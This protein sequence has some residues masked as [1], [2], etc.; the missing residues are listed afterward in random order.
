MLQ[1]E[2]TRFELIRY[3]FVT[4]INTIDNEFTYEV[5]D[6]LLTEDDISGLSLQSNNTNWVSVNEVNVIDVDEIGSDSF[7]SNRK[8]ICGLFNAEPRDWK[9]ARMIVSDHT[10]NKNIFAIGKMPVS[11]IIPVIFELQNT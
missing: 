3:E 8:R 11:P 2:K 7:E 10:N 9:Y 6:I 1:P 4:N 5:N